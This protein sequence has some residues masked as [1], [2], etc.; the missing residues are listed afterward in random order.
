MVEE[1]AGTSLYKTKRDATK[2]LIEKKEGKVRETSALLDEEVLPKLD[3]LRKERSAY[4]EYQKT[5]RDI[6]FLTHIHISARY[7]KLCDALQNVAATEQKI[8]NRIA[9]CRDTHTRNLEDIERADIKVKEIQQRIDAEMGGSL[10]TLEAQLAAKRAAEATASGSLKAAQGTI[11]QDEKKI[12]M[13]AKN[14]SEDEQALL[15][16][17][18]AMSKVQ[19]E[20]QSLK[21]ADANDEKAYENAKRKFEAVSQGLSTDEDGQACTLQEQLISKSSNI[22]YWFINFNINIFL[23]LPSNS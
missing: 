23:Q 16:K 6:E 8:E 22:T 7:L 11:Q 1:A 19:G 15:K 2:N 17:Q 18:E 20:F 12:Q 14:I 4:Q 5:C 10:K 21:D 9:V 3:K 13:V